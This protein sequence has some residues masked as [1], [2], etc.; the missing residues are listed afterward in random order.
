MQEILEN[1]IFIFSKK[2]KK[3][4]SSSSRCTTKSLYK[5]HDVKTWLSIILLYWKDIS[6]K[7]YVYTISHML[8]E[9]N[10]YHKRRKGKLQ[11]HPLLLE[12]LD[13]LHLNLGN[14]TPPNLQ[15]N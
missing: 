7:I 3:K 10:S 13:S 6:Y 14:D 4:G 9:W 8:W 2:K 12:K 15:N 5:R 11:W 1:E